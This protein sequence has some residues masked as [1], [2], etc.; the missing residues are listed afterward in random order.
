[1]EVL[2]ARCAGLDVHK[3]TVVAC[4]LFTPESGR[5]QQEVRTF[6]TTTRELL[7]L[8][9]WLREGGCTH[10]AMESTGE[11]WKP[12][13][14]LLEGHLE[15]L[16]VNP[17]HVKNVP[18]RKT[19]V[20]DAEWLADLLRHGLVKSSF[21]P[22]RPQRELRDLTRGRCNLIE[23][24]TRIVNR[25]QKVLEDAN[26]KLGD[27]ASDVTG[28]SGRAM[29]TALAQGATDPEALA[30]LA[31]GTLREKRAALAEALEGRVN[32][33]HRFLLTRH[34]EHLAFVEAQIAG[35]D[36]EIGRQLERMSEPATP[37][38]PTGAAGVPGTAD[39]KP[40]KRG[41][42]PSEPPTYTRAVELA[43]PIPGIG[44]RAVEAIFAEMGV[45]M[46]RFPTA[47]HL[48]AWA[49]VA[50][51]NRES[52]GKRLSGKTRHGNA[53]LR[54]ALVQAAHG[55]CRAKDTSFKA[56]YH[57]VAARRGRK[58]A[59]VAVARAILVVLYHVLLHQEPYHELGEGYLDERKREET[60]RHLTQRLRRLGYEVTLAAPAA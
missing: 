30:E 20:K 19:D 2:Y 11:Y 29:L 51:G 1:M 60:A 49:G 3:K 58:R 42:P 7:A 31:R 48:A 24:R 35:F 9:D 12:V 26:I 13:Y 56:L 16:L 33:H 41:Q 34:L 45:D 59:I 40:G 47:G 36:Q 17:Q 14:N 21:V 52:A 39:P 38:P 4:R 53:A 25:L 28:V 15:L 5:K 6:G 43:L 55:A 57:R 32:A 46:R 18:G 10:V 37:A 50:P 23:E 8:L 44:P 22:A 54:K 27:V